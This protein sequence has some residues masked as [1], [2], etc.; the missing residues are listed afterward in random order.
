MGAI[1]PLAGR[2]TVARVR[3]RQRVPRRG[4]STRGPASLAADAPHP[5]RRARRDRSPAR[6]HPVWFH[7]PTDRVVSSTPMTRSHWAGS[8]PRAPPPRPRSP[9]S[10]RC[11]C[12]RSPRRTS[13]APPT[14]P[15][16]RPTAR[17]R[18][19]PA[20]GCR[21]QT[22]ASA[23]DNGATKVVCQADSLAR[24]AAVD[25]RTP[26]PTATCCARRSRRVK[27]TR[28]EGTALLRLNKKLL[29]KLRLQLDPGRGQRLRQQRPRRDHARALH[30]AASR[31]APTHDPA[32]A[33]YRIIND[34]GE[35]G[36]VSYK[37]QFHCPTTRT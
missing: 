9:S 21:R 17:S 25:R 20:D 16:R 23:L 22:L 11:S 10:S 28:A 26:R 19:V 5:R 30:R 14:G 3:T 12:R 15:T 36:A 6:Q 31:A 35:T 24:V 4:A 34:K 7:S 2:S 29:K 32:C 18:R 33:Q 37:Y 1:R 27:I 13:S 8:R